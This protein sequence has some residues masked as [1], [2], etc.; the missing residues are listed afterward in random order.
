MST[1]LPS[2]L[3]T[4]KTHDL[5]NANLRSQHSKQIYQNILARLQNDH[6]QCKVHSHK[7]IYFHST[8]DASSIARSRC[9]AI[10]SSRVLHEAHEAESLM[11]DME[12][13]FCGTIREQ[14]RRSRAAKTASEAVPASCSTG[15][16]AGSGRGSRARAAA[17]AAEP[18]AAKAAASVSRSAG[19]KHT[20]EGSPGK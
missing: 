5:D 3:A 18:M 16:R 4:R 8:A 9:C 14:Q 20:R 13:T 17:G 7:I 1:S 11:T 19:F 6:H 10:S 12:I 15:V 2:L